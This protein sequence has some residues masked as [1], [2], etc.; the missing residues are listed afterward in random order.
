M[1]N[2]TR[3][4]VANIGE[5]SSLRIE[6]C[7][8]RKRIARKKSIVAAL[9]RRIEAF[10]QLH[11]RLQASAA[12]DENQ[13]ASQNR[14]C[15]ISGSTVVSCPSNNAAQKPSSTAK[16]Y[17]LTKPPVQKISFH[18]AIVRARKPDAI[19]LLNR[20]I[21]QVTASDPFLIFF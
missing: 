5:N 17:S 20:E 11:R 18:F 13:A 10:E 1:K 16:P 6:R 8:C 15:S 12:A 19:F 9:Q 3:D 7:K 21:L 2:E 4:L 14:I